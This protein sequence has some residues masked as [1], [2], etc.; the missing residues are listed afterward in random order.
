MIDNE[1]TILHTARTCRYCLEGEDNGEDDKDLIAPCKCSGSAKYVHREC[2]KSWFKERSSRIVI[3]GTLRQF[4]RIHRC[5][6]CNTDYNITHSDTEPGESLN[7]T[8]ARYFIT[9]TTALFVSYMIIGYLMRLDSCLEHLFV[10]YDRIP[11]NS[12]VNGFISVH[13]IIGAFYIVVLAIGIVSA[14]GCLCDFFLFIN[15]NDVDDCLGTVI[16]VG[17]IGILGTVLVIYYDVLTRVVQRHNTK[18]VHVIDILPCDRVE[19]VL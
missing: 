16:I 13:L 19:D 15:C 6:L 5:E 3:P 4:T 14:D 18:K 1:L 8:I 2:L 9:L 12:L 10:D 11:V 17:F 7:G